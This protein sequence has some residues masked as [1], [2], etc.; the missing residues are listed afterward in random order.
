MHPGRLLWIPAVG[1][2]AELPDGK[3]RDVWSFEEPEFLPVDE[4][5]RLSTEV[6][7]DGAVLARWE[8]PDGYYLYRHRFGFETRVSA[9][10]ARLARDAGRTPRFRQA[11]KRSTS[12]SARSKS[13]T[14][15]PR[16]G[17][18]SLPVPVSS[19]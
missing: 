6:A 11:R 16:R 1:F 9:T 19:K 14:T 3:P 18:R 17:C 8:M 12:I 15:M 7:P 2:A 4:A 10:D 13:T 5:F